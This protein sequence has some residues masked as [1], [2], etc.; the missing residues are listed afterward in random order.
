MLA[1]VLI[2]VVSAA[3]PIAGMWGSD[4]FPSLPGLAWGVK[5][6]PVFKTMTQEALSGRETRT[7]CMM[8]PVWEYALSYEVLRADI[9]LAEMQQLCGFF[10]GQRGQY[11][12]WNYVDPDDYQVLNQPIGVG[13]GTKTQF[14]LL[15]SFGGFAE[16]VSWPRHHVVRVDGV[17]VAYS[18][19]G[20][21]ATLVVAPPVGA[22]V[23]WTGTFYYR[24]RFKEDAAQFQ[25]FARRLWDLQT[26]EFR[27]DLGDRI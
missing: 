27:A 4:V 5:K 14:Q 2:P 6:S 17:A 10:L 24:A 15:R 9:Y 25:Q 3:D 16:P 22:E 13:D 18:L 8:Y 20:G 12:S 1:S 26:L 23:T 11:G 19:A 7:A 21:V